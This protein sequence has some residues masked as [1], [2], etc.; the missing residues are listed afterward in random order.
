MS[1]KSPPHI[2]NSLFIRPA[3]AAVNRQSLRI[4]K[5]R[6]G[7]AAVPFPEY[8]RYLRRVDRAVELFRIFKPIIHKIRQ[9]AC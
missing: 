2:C 6:R 3:T 7:Y 9:H 4:G 5:S 1:R 8:I